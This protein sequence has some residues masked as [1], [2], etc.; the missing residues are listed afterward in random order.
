VRKPRK[1]KN[2]ILPIRLKPADETTL[3]YL[4]NETGLGD[5]ALIRFGLDCADEVL[6]CYLATRAE[7]EEVLDLERPITEEALRMLR[8]MAK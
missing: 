4:R 3:A 7:W 6:G 5:T 2:R 1:A 8:Q